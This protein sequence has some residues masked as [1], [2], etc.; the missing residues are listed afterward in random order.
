MYINYS[1]HRPPD[2]LSKY[3]K[4]SVYS[5]F[6]QYLCCTE[7][8]F[9]NSSHRPPGRQAKKCIGQLCR[10]FLQLYSDF[11]RELIYAFITPHL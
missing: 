7:L 2:H 1:S 6:L 11:L 8:I 9:T 5:Y 3:L 10:E 4:K